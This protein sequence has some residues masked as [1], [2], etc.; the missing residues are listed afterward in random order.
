MPDISDFI[1]RKGGIFFNIYKISTSAPI[2]LGS[3]Y[4]M[5]TKFSF[6]HYNMFIAVSRF[7]T[8]SVGGRPAKTARPNC[9][10]GLHQRPNDPA[11]PGRNGS[12]AF[13]KLISR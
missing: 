5:S 6:M 9:T 1:I 8:G 2:R 4:R 3:I 11:F 13:D 12:P 7:I 10:L